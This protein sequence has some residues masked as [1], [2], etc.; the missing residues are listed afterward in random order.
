MCAYETSSLPAALRNQAI[1]AGLNWFELECLSSDKVCLLPL[2][3]LKFEFGVSYD[4]CLSLLSRR[5][6]T[7]NLRSIT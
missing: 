5:K 6:V 3:V 1:E 2:L 7:V 4:T